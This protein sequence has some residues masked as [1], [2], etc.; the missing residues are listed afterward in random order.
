MSP[1]EFPTPPPAPHAPTRASVMLKHN[2]VI[3][4]YEL[5]DEEV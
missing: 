1:R 2:S 4:V 3:K 5:G